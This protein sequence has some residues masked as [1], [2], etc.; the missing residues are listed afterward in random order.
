M[1]DLAPDVKSVNVPQYV[2]DQSQGYTPLKYESETMTSSFDKTA[3]TIA[4]IV[5]IIAEAGD[6][7]VKNNIND[8]IRRGTDA[9]NK[10]FGVNATVALY[11]DKVPEVP[12]DL[13]RALK[14]VERIRVAKEQGAL[15]DTAYDTKL[16][17]MASSLRSKYDSPYLRDYIDAR[18]QK[19]TGVD[20]ANKIRNDIFAAQKAQNSAANYEEKQKLQLAEKMAGEGINVTQDDL[21]LPYRSLILKYGAEN[22]ILRE[23]KVNQIAY[24]ETTNTRSLADVEVKRNAQFGLQTFVINGINNINGQLGKT[25]AE[26]RANLPAF[27]GNNMSPEKKV[28]FTT[29]V[30]QYTDQVV[31]KSRQWLLE[32]YKGYNLT[33]DVVK[34]ILTPTTMLMDEYR[35][36]VLTGN[37]SYLKDLQ[38]NLEISKTTTDSK[39]MSVPEIAKVASVN[40]ILGNTAGGLA[41]QNSLEKVTK[42]TDRV[43]LAEQRNEVYG[44]K[45]GIPLEQ[46]FREAS[47][48]GIRSPAVYQ[49]SIQYPLDV[50]SNPESHPEAVE[51]AV[52]TLYAKDNMN[53]YAALPPNQKVGAYAQIF[54]DKAMKAVLKIKEGGDPKPYQMFIES[55]KQSFFPVFRQAAVSMSGELSSPTLFD[56][57][58]NIERHQFDVTPK[59]Y[60][61]PMLGPSTTPVPNE[62]R[63][64][65]GGLATIAPILEENKENPEQYIQMILKTLPLD[66]K[67]WQTSDKLIERLNGSFQDSIKK[68]AVKGSEGKSKVKGSPAEDTLSSESATGGAVPALEVGARYEGLLQVGTQRYNDL[69]EQFKKAKN[70][71]ALQ[72]VIQQDFKSFKEEMTRQMEELKKLNDAFKEFTPTQ[73]EPNSR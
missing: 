70:D 56:V 45:N 20:P 54:S 36:A 34:D 69:K 15:G 23:H 17:S 52:R 1:A 22:R 31:A 14:E 57:K 30:R 62:V 41:Y 53:F 25:N 7:I 3:G 48:R 50:I 63:V 21:K 38:D 40:R 9:L 42:A 71:P 49:A 46:T 19:V 73:P 37:A 39:M 16:E 11:N 26:I 2:S 43:F 4:K 72:S 27:M 58:Y 60:V 66:D 33:E 59:E 55:A 13:E 8:E 65:N 61:D 18:I 32:N 68:D 28:Q 67:N 29:Q 47:A 12:A 5:P 51:K 6:K 35:N 44:T 24:E 64:I 10:E